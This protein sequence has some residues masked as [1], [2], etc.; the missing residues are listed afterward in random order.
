[1]EE[2]RSIT[3]I[4]ELMQFRHDQA[5][6]PDSK[7]CEKVTRSS[8]GQARSIKEK[9]EQCSGVELPDHLNVSSNYHD[10]FVETG[11][12][13]TLVRQQYPDLFKQTPQERTPIGFAA[14][15]NH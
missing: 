12:W 15:V 4:E 1:M 7:R 3:A 5:V 6:L 2:Q 11:Q 13:L 14:P 8:L 10:L 9:I